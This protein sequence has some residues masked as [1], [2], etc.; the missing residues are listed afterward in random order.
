MKL[1]LGLTRGGFD[2]SLVLSLSLPTGAR[3]ISS[4][5]YDPF[6][7]LPWSRTLSSNWMLAAMLTLAWLKSKARRVASF[8]TTK[9]RARADCPRQALDYHWNL[10]ENMVMR[11]REFLQ[12]AVA[13]GFAVRPAA[14]D[15]S[16]VGR[17]TS[18]SNSP[19]QIQ[20]ALKYNF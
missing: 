19:R 10:G 2:V 7:E 20:F 17:I 5:G 12:S 16:A 6:V 18:T 15:T 13:S 3:A 1:Q 9:R 14:A 4:R 11:R 8:S